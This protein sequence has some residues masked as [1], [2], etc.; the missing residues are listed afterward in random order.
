MASSPQEARSNE[1]NGW[2]T[3]T[4]EEFFGKPVVTNSVLNDDLVY[5]YTNKFGKK[6]HHR[7]SEDTIKKKLNG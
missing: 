2:V 3:V 4:K 1:I 6:P 5:Q 7:M